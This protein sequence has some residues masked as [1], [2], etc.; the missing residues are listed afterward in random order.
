MEAEETAE[1]DILAE[2]EQALAEQL[3]IMRNRTRK[4]VD[5]LQYAMSIAAEDLA[6]Y[7]P[8]F[9]WEMGPPTPM[10]LQSLE[11]R[12]I[13]PDFVENSG[14]VSVLIARLKKR[15]TEGLSTPRQ[16]RC[17][18]RYGFRQVGTWTFD[19]A[20]ALISRLAANNWHIP[21]GMNVSAYAP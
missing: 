17:L 9:A 14:K 11:R 20:N 21:F 5:P 12:G 18:E 1:R 13:L 10:Q 16:I 7:E 8:T 6:N 15:Q 4:L 3:A 2:R 19:Q